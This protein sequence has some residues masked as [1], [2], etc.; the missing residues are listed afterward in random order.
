MS[1]HYSQATIA[2]FPS[3]VKIVEVGPRDGLQNEKAIVPAQTKIEF[4][5][6]LSET[7][8]SVI[9]VTSFVSPKWI[10][11]MADHTEVMNGIKRHPGVIYQAL[12]P[13]VKGFQSAINAKV[14]EIA[15][16][17]AAS[18]SF[19]KKNINCSIE[20]S[21]KRFDAVLAEAKKTN[22][23]VR[24]YVSCVLGCP[25]EGEIDPEKV[26]WV[27]K[28]MLDMGCYEISLGD[29]IGVGTPGKMKTLI[30][31]VSRD[32][33]IQKLAVHCHD[34]YGQALANIFAA[35]QM[36]ISVVD[37]SVAGL[38]GCPYA[39]GASGNVSTEDVVYLMNGLAIKTDVN[40]QK[41]IE[42]GNFISS[43]L[44][45]QTHSKVAQ[46]TKSSL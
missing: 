8:L 9:E 24:G 44:G 3:F 39:K 5:N 23:P 42:A 28:K 13:N 43:A 2:G 31:T 37:S 45:R 18:E 16:F 12:V 34:T 29:T 1:K 19:S 10:P 41:L 35:L 46:A 33:P 30:S 25:Y 21:L 38:G 20:D 32:V 22:T 7:G 27:S 26:A 15:I 14:D 6:K 40:I 36:G 11:Q 4:I 17:G